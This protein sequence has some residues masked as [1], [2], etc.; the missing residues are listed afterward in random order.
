MLRKEKALEIT[1]AQAE[2]PARISTATIDRRLA[3]ERAKLLRC[4]RSPTNP[5]SLLNPKFRSV[6]GRNGMTPVPG[7]LGID[8]VGHDRSN[9]SWQFR[10]TLTVTDFAPY[11]G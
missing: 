2:L 10:F 8:M 6:L 3:G 11:V 9:S 4:E 5:G 7:F 1:D